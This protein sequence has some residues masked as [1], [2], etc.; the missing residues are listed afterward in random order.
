[1]DILELQL[2]LTRIDH[3]QHSTLFS[4]DAH[5]AGTLGPKK[6]VHTYR[7]PLPWSEPRPE[8]TTT[9]FLSSTAQVTCSN[10]EGSDAWHIILSSAW[11]WTSDLLHQARFQDHYQW[12]TLLHLSLKTLRQWVTLL[13]WPRRHF[14][15]IDNKN[16][17][18]NSAN[19]LF[20]PILKIILS[21]IA[22]SCTIFYN[23]AE[24]WLFVF[25]INHLRL[26]YTSN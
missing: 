11:K 22:Q 7:R 1:M 21:I 17:K 14:I 20:Q 2:E 10:G 12:A 16:N 18:Q 5:S 26:I 25:D 19:W 4:H 8:Q 23:K 15:S 13:Y 9:R 3:F 6:R 24:T